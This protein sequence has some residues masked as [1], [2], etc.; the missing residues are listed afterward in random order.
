VVDFDSFVLVVA[1]VV[2]VVG[3]TSAAVA[4]HPAVLQS[5]SLVVL[6]HTDSDNRGNYPLTPYCYSSLD[7]GKSLVSLRNRVKGQELPWIP[8]S[9]FVAPLG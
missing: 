1:E 9:L 7:L 8:F 3:V 5:Y 4:A 2:P 6:L